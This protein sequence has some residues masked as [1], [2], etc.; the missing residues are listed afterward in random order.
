MLPLGDI[1][2]KHS[3]DFH[4]YA[5][6]TQLYLSF[7]ANEHNHLQ[8]LKSCVTDI[9]TW[10]T[11][12]FL[13]LNSDKSELLILGPKLIR[14]SI[15]DIISSDNSLI[16]ATTTPVKNLGV[17][18]D[19]DL[20]FNSHINYI[21][22]TAYFHLRNIRKV[23]Q[24]VPFNAAEKL[25]HA[26]VTSRLDYCNVLLAGCSASSLRTLQL[27]QNTAAR[28]LTNTRQ[29]DHISPVLAS[30][31]WLPVLYRIQ[32]KILLLTFKALHGVAP[33]YI[34]DLIEPCQPTRTLRSVG[35]GLL[36]VPRISKSR[37]GAKAFCYQAPLLW[38]RLPVPVREADTV[39]SFKSKLK[40]HLFNTAHGSP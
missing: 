33:S 36:V 20:S 2:R 28:V 22:K 39:L 16:T 13:M 10:M 23:R 1:I 3:I 27:I 32:F 21:S 8:G 9:K 19:Q 12:N 37:F 26:F 25:V 29:R 14:D 11:L 31:H 15:S 35:A 38:N 24:L 4:C 40:T 34:V 18:F 17:L 30:L 5:D 6:D 7:K